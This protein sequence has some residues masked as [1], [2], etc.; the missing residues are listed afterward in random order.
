M[1]VGISNRGEGGALYLVKVIIGFFLTKSV[2]TECICQSR[3]GGV[4]CQ[5]KTQVLS[6][7]CFNLCESVVTGHA[8]RLFLAAEAST[9]NRDML[10]SSFVSCSKAPSGSDMIESWYGIDRTEDTNVSACNC[11]D[12]IRDAFN[13]KDFFF[14]RCTFSNNLCRQQFWFHPKGVSNN[15]EECNLCNNSSHESGLMIS[16]N[17]PTICEECVFL[18]NTFSLLCEHNDLLETIECK[19]YANKFSQGTYATSLLLKYRA[20]AMCVNVRGSFMFSFISQVTFSLWI[21]VKLSILIHV[22]GL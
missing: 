15:F 22:V 11:I 20:T 21:F 7:L 14:K 5:S 16:N 3:G 12:Y 18:Q 4:Y 1:F 6:N 9:E 17:S 8:A 19:F 10:W 13:F 2:F